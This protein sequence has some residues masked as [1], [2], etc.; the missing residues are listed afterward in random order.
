MFALAVRVHGLLQRLGALGHLGRLG[1]KVL[2]VLRQLGGHAH[3]LGD[4]LDHGDEMQAA[5][6]AVA[7]HRAAGRHP[8][9]AAVVPQIALLAP[10]EWQLPAQHL[11]QLRPLVAPVLGVGQQTEVQ[12]HQRFAAVAGDLAQ[13]RIVEIPFPHARAAG[14]Q[15]QGQPGF[16]GAQRGFGQVAVGDVA[17][18]ADGQ[19]AVRVVQAVDAGLHQP[20][21]AVGA[22]PVRLEAGFFRRVALQHLPRACFRKVDVPVP[23]PQG[24]GVVQAAAQQTGERLVGLQQAAVAVQCEKCIRCMGKQRT[25]P[26]QRAPRCRRLFGRR[27]WRFRHGVCQSQAHRIW[28]R[29]RHG[30][31]ELVCEVAFAAATTLR[32]FASRAPQVAGHTL[33]AAPAPC[34]CRQERPPGKAAKKGR[35]QCRPCPPPC[36][37]AS[38]A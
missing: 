36:P 14:L 25:P 4:V 38:S 33:T 13:V 16:A 32:W 18:A 20:Q 8:D 27:Q 37:N 28:R 35:T 10:K 22:A 3:P 12:R 11:A 7:H 2:A 31:E 26:G 19:P 24:H 23:Q 6:V 30:V 17:T 15:R 9:A 5:V 21:L 34:E 29:V 1:L